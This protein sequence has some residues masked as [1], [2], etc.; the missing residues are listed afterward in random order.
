MYNLYN[1]MLSKTTEPNLT[2]LQKLFFSCKVL[3]TYKVT[4]FVFLK[5]L[6]FVLC[7]HYKLMKL[8]LLICSL[9]LLSLWWQQLLGKTY[10]LRS[11]LFDWMARSK[12]WM[13]KNNIQP[14]ITWKLSQNRLS[15]TTL[16]LATETQTNLIFYG[17]RV[18]ES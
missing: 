1:G 13:I 16:L 18:G 7:I 11:C 15:Y 4:N 5:M 2:F 12:L 6:L 8:N 10:G 17:G 3:H 14:H 9:L